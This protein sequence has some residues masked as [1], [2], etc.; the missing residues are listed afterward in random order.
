MT[1]VGES[2]RVKLADALTVSEIV[3]DAVKFPCVPLMV[4]VAEPVVDVEPADRVNVL[5]DPLATLAG[6][7]AAV[8]PFGRPVAA[9]VALP[10]NPF[11]AASEMELVPPGAP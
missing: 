9:S 7:N 2:A 5:G 3:V 11:S 6:L 8:T 10:V 4:M 1:L